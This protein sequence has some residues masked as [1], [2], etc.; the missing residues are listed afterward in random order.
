MMIISCLIPEKIPV[1]PEELPAIPKK[2]PAIPEKLL[3]HR[4][5]RKDSLLNSVDKHVTDPAIAYRNTYEELSR[6][7]IFTNN[8]KKIS[9]LNKTAGVFY[10]TLRSFNDYRRI[11]EY[12]RMIVQ[13][14]DENSIARRALS[15]S[16][17][18]T[19]WYKDH[20]KKYEQNV[21]LLF[22]FLNSAL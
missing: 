7:G 13:Y 12:W 6:R 5:N 20:H 9:F 16:I 11:S 22:T 17:G 18:V 15:F 19:W 2:L 8:T 1:I 3:Y 14:T 4:V 21:F 10:Y